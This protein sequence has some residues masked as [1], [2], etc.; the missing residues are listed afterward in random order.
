MRCRIRQSNEDRLAS[1]RLYVLEHSPKAVPRC[2]SAPDDQIHH[3][4]RTL[5]IE[6]Q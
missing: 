3:V 4:L 5:A 1:K 2:W 6:G